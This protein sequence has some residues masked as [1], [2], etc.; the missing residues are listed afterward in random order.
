M[1][2]SFY[3][4]SFRRYRP[5]NPSVAPMGSAVANAESTSM[6][7]LKSTKST[8][9]DRQRMVKVSGNQRTDWIRGYGHWDVQ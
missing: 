4:E 1:V 9:V 2:I 7:K 8:V 6:V 5:P 3:R